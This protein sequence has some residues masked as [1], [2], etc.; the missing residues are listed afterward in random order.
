M[1]ELL[2]VSSSQAARL[3]FSLRRLAARGTTADLAHDGWGVAFYQGAD[4]ALFR[5]SVA[6][7]D[8]ALVR[9]LERNGPSTQLAVSHIRHATWG[10]VQ[11][12]NTQP[13]IRELG[14]H[15][16]TFA[17]N[18][19]L[20]QIDSCRALA[21]VMDTPIGQTDSELAFCALMT[22]MRRL[23]G[24]AGVP[25]LA[26]RMSLLAIFAKD[27]RTLGA[28]NFLYADGDTLFAHGHLRATR[29]DGPLEAPGLWTL[30]RRCTPAD[31]D[32]IHVA[33]M[34]AEH[35]HT[36]AV[37]VASVPLT[38]EAWQ[39]MYAG[40]LIAVRDGQVIASDFN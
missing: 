2:A 14:G 28:A 31:A 25:S 16:H 40:E 37:L 22:R 6:A 39:P 18:G 26:A 21:L 3:T 13:F 1:C 20:T 38:G 11:F 7:A 35:G 5:E 19:Y 4:A 33:G 12:S 10:A 29:L 34:V 8:S 27:L 32:P 30:R 24:D 36:S 9:F 17:H 23:W 15:T